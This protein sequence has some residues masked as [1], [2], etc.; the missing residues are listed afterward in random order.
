MKRPETPQRAPGCALRI[1]SGGENHQI[2]FYQA[3]TL[4]ICSAALLH[5]Q[6][7][8]STQIPKSTLRPKQLV[9][10]KAPKRWFKDLIKVMFMHEE[11]HENSWERK[12]FGSQFGDIVA[13]INT[14]ERHRVEHRNNLSDS[15]SQFTS[16]FHLSFYS[17]QVKLV[18][19]NMQN[20]CIINHGKIRT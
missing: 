14:D 15:S 8:I 5:L 19:L 7:Q 3:S 11:L 13:L 12:P 9:T 17:S 2:N 16:C 6:G 1:K 20:K 10:P 18:Y 4:T